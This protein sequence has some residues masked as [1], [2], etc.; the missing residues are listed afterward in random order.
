MKGMGNMKASLSSPASGFERIRHTVRGKE[1]WFARELSR[2]LEYAQ[3]RNFESVID[4]AID[5][6]KNSKVAVSDHFAH[7]RKMVTLGSGATR[8]V[9]DWKLSR[10]AC[11]LIVQNGDP[12]KPVIAQG[13]SYF[14]VQARRQEIS[15]ET[16]FERLSEDERRIMLRNELNHHNKALSAAARAAGVGSSLDYAIFQD[17]G[18]RGLYGG[19][20]AKDIHKA[21]GLKK[22]H[23][24]LDHM[25]SIEL[26][27]NL[28]RTTQTEE[29]L[30]RERVGSKALAN[31]MHHSVGQRVRVTIR[32]LGGTM[33][34]A[35]PV[36]RKSI[37]QLERE[38]AKRLRDDED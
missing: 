19:R 29:K 11:Y 3:Y 21:K 13:Q 25:G 18:Y 15:D 8:A 37:P 38:K 9:E 20:Q 4:R 17:H 31:K 7:M 10:Y 30:R 5:A 27:A 35:L 14:A 28:F 6:C 16:R 33:P 22:S 36:P 12:A 26:A 2:V 24:I 1:F 23:K 34:E 32:D